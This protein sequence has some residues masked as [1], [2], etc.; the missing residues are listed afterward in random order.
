MTSDASGKI[1][2]YVKGFAT[3]R[4]PESLTAPDGKI[5]VPE[6]TDLGKL[7]GIIGIPEAHRTEMLLLV[8]GRNCPL[9]HLLA[10][11]DRV[12]FFPPMTGG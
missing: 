4:L 2:I 8:N 9:D 5:T 12:V 10:S 3:V 7:L 1:E 6:G 11:E